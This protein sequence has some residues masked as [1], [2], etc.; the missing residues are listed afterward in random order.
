[1]NNDQLYLFSQIVG[2]LMCLVTAWNY[3]SIARI[4]KSSA[5]WVNQL[6]A[7]FILSFGIEMFSHVI[8]Y[9]APLPQ[10]LVGLYEVEAAALVAFALL[11]SSMRKR[12]FLRKGFDQYNL[13]NR[14]LVY[15]NQLFETFM[16]EMPAMVYL[17]D[18]ENRFSYVNRKFCEVFDVVPEQ[19]LGKEY[20]AW[21]SAAGVDVLEHEPGVPQFGERRECLDEFTFQ[22]R[23][24]F[25]VSVKFPLK[26]MRDANVIAAFC[27]EVTASVRNKEVDTVLAS[28]VKLSPDAIYTISDKGHIISWNFGA[29]RM[30]GY[31]PEEI[32]GLPVTVLAPL[33]LKSEAKVIMAEIESGRFVL[34][35]ETVRVT[36]SGER[37]NVLL[38]A[39]L[40]K[41]LT[42]NG[43]HYSVIARDITYLK[44][45]ESRIR[46]LNEE[47]NDRIAELTLANEELQKARDQALDAA[48]MKSAFV[49]TVSHQLRTP[50]SGVLGLS[51]LLLNKPLET[52]Q[53]TMVETIL[54]ST[55]ALL[56]IVSDIADMSKLDVGTVKVEVS[57]FN[58]ASL[59][60]ESV[61]LLQP[62]AQKKKLSLTVTLDPLLPPDVCGD[63]QK[64]RQVLFNLVGN[65]IKFT[66]DGGVQIKVSL[67]EQGQPLLVRFSVIDTGIG[68]SPDEGH[69]LFA[70]FMRIERSTKGVPGTGLGLCISKRLINLMGGELSFL[71]EKGRGSE[72]YFLVQ[73]SEVAHL[74]ALTFAA[75]EGRRKQQITKTILHRYR[76]LS[77]EDNS[78]LAEISMRQLA[79][80]GIEAELAISGAEALQKTNYSDGPAF[81][82]LLMDI[83]LPDISGY[84]V[85]KIIR[86]REQSGIS[87]RHIIIAMTAGAMPGDRE[88]ALN[89]GMDDYLSKPV[90][91]KQLSETLVSWLEET[92]SIEPKLL[93]SLD[94]PNQGLS[95]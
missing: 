20:N 33:D 6:Y 60:N 12:I 73:L 93:R 19:L 81:D 91:L 1:M 68:I 89:A 25:W 55:E 3:F 48:C 61:R 76:V 39:S 9:P 15:A 44:Q 22:G 29:E 34:D 83:N 38:S 37:K 16:A 85:T 63:Q 17:L 53:R 84:D 64:I 5:A 70:P 50:I 58:L 66:F 36:K 14:K 24:S 51:E 56:S 88:K 41:S 57:A 18:L 46:E 74:A 13:C 80:L 52:E 72:F 28:I 75:N 92:H 86:G 65:A 2:S 47:L 82:V 4:R 42:N 69:Q 94:I 79:S 67:E 78:I 23:R 71:S 49:D 87:P 27:F 32:I 95:A 45:V 31:Q 54:E 30:F 26:G 43:I 11:S 77:V 59:L 35:R 8:S 62:S 40:M 10:F 90:N 7:L 21:L